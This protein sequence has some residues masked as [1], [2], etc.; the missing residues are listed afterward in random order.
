MK[1]AVPT[2]P[3]CLALALTTNTHEAILNACLHKPLQE[4]IE[5]MVLQQQVTCAQ[6][7]A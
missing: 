2:Y 4:L 6:S 5:S 7:I 3:Q 1:F